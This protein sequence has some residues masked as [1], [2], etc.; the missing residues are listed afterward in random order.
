MISAQ[1]TEADL[2]IDGEWRPSSS[3]ERFDVID[4]ATGEVTARVANA[5]ED[6]VDAAVAVAQEA[7]LDQRWLAIPPLERGR[8]LRRIAELIR[9]HHDELARLMTRENGMPIN[10]ARFI[11]IPLAA[12]CFDFFASLVVK[13]QGEV[14]PFSVAGAAPDYMAWTMKEPI[15]VAGLITPW[16]FPLLMPA[17]KIA[18]ALA[19][20]CTMVLKPAPETPLTALKLAELCQ[21]AGVPDGVVNV[22]PGRDEA[23]KALVRHPSVPKIA[24]TGETATGRH[25]LQ[26]AAP[27]IKRVTLELGGKSPNIIFADADLE[28]AAKSALFG[29]FYNSGQVCQA[30]SRILVE[31]PV[32]E[33]FVQLLADRANTLRMG[34]GMNARTDIGPV[35]SREQYDKVLHYIDIGRQE[36]AKL[37]AGGSARPELGGYFI[38]PTIFA[39]VKPSM[40][41]A[42]EEIFGPVAAVIPFED[43]EEAASIANDTMY[44]LAA[45]V[46]TNDIKRALRL[47]RR[48]K[49]GTVW[50]NTYQV[51]SPTAPFGGYKQSG[52]G[53]ELGMQALEPYL[54]TKTVICDVNDRPMTLF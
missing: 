42:R 1:T 36:G 47:A 3:G 24:F 48:V 54:E 37:V 13:P 23:G 31:R 50:I 30:G 11:E 35:V 20:G 49:S 28:Q 26:A 22:L 32:Y 41:I 16:N 10:M 43:E 19:A 25:I 46:W 34:P 8:I 51:L 21:E 33:T 2:W 39:D 29:V 45:A 4:P 6:D 14:L 27:H 12:D 17:W 9:Q 5:G 52:L 15:G 53:R 38:E 18:P 7:F 44:G 40:R